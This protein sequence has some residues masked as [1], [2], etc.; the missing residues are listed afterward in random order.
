MKNSSR[1]QTL[2][3]KQKVIELMN[4]VIVE[5]LNRVTVH[6]NAKLEDPE[7][8]LFDEYTPKLA[9]CTYGSDEYKTFLAG[10]KPALDHHYARYRHHPEHFPQGCKDM[11]LVDVLEMLVDWKA[12]TLRHN[13]GNILKSL[14][15]NRTRFALDKVTLYDI[16]M[17]SVSMFEEHNT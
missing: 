5:L 8:S 13:D 14:E 3:H 11:N 2:E 7:V 1:E 6:D 9:A 4:A 10:L 17:N 15:H 16:L 12:A